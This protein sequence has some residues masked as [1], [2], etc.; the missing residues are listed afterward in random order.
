MHYHIYSNKMDDPIQH[1]K[2]NS[3]NVWVDPTQHKKPLIN[4]GLIQFSTI[5]RKIHCKNNLVVLTTEWLP[6]KQ[7]SIP[8]ETYH[9]R[10]L[11]SLSTTM[12]TTLRLNQPSCC[13]SVKPISCPSQCKKKGQSRMISRR[14]SYTIN[15]LLCVCKTFC[16]CSCYCPSRTSLLEN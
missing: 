5:P 15:V 14:E 2:F 4:F 8:R 3:G 10:C 9:N 16:C 11:F 13:C 7:S 6:C 1:K 12:V